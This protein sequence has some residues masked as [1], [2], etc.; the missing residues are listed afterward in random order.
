MQ[1]WST[2]LRILLRVI[3]HRGG[4]MML[5]E[6]SGVSNSQKYAVAKSLKNLMFLVFLDPEVSQDNFKR[7]DKV[8][9]RYPQRH[10][11]VVQNRVQKR[12]KNASKTEQ[13][14]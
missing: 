11:K 14:K 3:G 5:R 6:M 9:K 13:K 2:I 4:K 1:F 12:L 10:L 7:P 8:S